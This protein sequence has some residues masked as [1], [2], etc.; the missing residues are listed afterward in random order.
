MYVFSIEVTELTSEE[1][2][3]EVKLSYRDL[4]SFNGDYL[5]F[6]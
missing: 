1:I 3:S 6:I 2:N 5:T 4:I